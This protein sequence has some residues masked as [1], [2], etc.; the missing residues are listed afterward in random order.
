MKFEELIIE[1]SNGTFRHIASFPSPLFDTSGKLSGGINV[2]VDI[3]ER[4][5][6]EVEL[7]KLSLIAK[8]T[9]NAVLITSPEGHIE[10]VNDAF[11]RITGYS[12]EEV[13]GK[14]ASDFLHG[15][16]TDPKVVAWMNEKFKN[17][18]AFECELVKYTKGGKTFWMEIQA[19]P[20]FDKKGKLVSYFD[21]ETDI[22]DRK[23]AFEEL[24]KKENEIRTF[25]R[26]QNNILEEE[27]S[28]LAREIHDEFGQQLTGIKMSLSSLRNFCTTNHPAR[29]LASDL[30]SDVECSIRVLRNIATDLRP[31]IL[32]TMGLIPSI[33][34]LVK[35]FEKKNNIQIKLIQ[36]VGRQVFDP[37]LSIVIFRICQ[38][39]LTNIS[40]HA[41]ADEVIV[42]I[43]Q[44]RK[45][46]ALVISDNGKGIKEEK[47][48]DP[49]S[50]GLIGMRER[51]SLIGAQLQ[52][53]S[54]RNKGTTIQFTATIN[55]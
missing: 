8:N 44:K 14:K 55:D 20:L 42:C 41:E 31:G 51:A 9:I 26:Q 24:V 19:Q 23:N 50:I 47:L 17:K 11:S 15:K 5:K 1:R 4:K 43:T 46:L 2:L 49:F 39:A 48:K 13:V 28:R 3:T 53:K 29:E 35:E 37:E 21:L 22:T 18:E 6:V 40:R 12:Y 38:E 7:N 32:D 52:V 30:I 34:W 27:R 16:K 10:W 45:E 33:E 54:Y 25:A 36:K